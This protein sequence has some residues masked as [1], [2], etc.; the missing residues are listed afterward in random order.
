MTELLLIS[1]VHLQLQVFVF[2]LLLNNFNKSS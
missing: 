1:F 2:K